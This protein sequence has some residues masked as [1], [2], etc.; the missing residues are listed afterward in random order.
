MSNDKIL[1]KK[2]RIP[3]I[4]TKEW[5]IETFKKLKND[6]KKKCLD[7]R[8]RNLLIHEY[9]YYLKQIYNTF[10]ISKFEP[11]LE[12][13]ESK[14]QKDIWLAF[15]LK[16]SSFE[17]SNF[18]KGRFIRILI[19]D[20]LTKKYIGIAS[21]KSD[22]DCKLYDDYIGWSNIDKYNYKLFNNLMNITT[23]V[24]IPPFSFNYNAGKLIAMLMFS[25]E[26]YDYVYEKYNNEL[27]CIV[28]FSLYGKSIQ[29]DRLKELKY[30]GLT[31]GESVSNIPN[32]FNDS[33]K[34]YMEK[35]KMKTKFKSRLYRISYLIK[36]FNFPKEMK[37]GIQKGVYIGFT[38]VNSIEFLTRKNKKFVVKKLNNVQQIG[39][40]WKERWAYNRIKHLL[41]TERIMFNYNYDISVVDNKDYN[42]IK[43]IRKKQKNNTINNKL[44]DKEKI[45]II[46]YF[47]ENKPSM[48][49]MSK[50]FI[51]KFNKPIDRRTIN[52]LINCI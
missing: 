45:Q 17:Y 1:Q 48:A 34:K 9:S 20:K 42:R 30:L 35:N 41:N 51:D 37:E 43:Q 3:E 22:L 12:F 21:L 7:Y 19:R 49:N 38:G 6:D 23:C 11:E 47:I 15:R 46:K 29:Y 52:K 4:I 32:W 33:I 13:C 5:I 27:T 44:T 10:D 31:K 40:I 16:I 28:T 8:S 2:V 26:V 36:R 50:L 14:E 25:K 24:A 18:G 39:E